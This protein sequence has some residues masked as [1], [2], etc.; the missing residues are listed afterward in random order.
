M[1]ERADSM[2]KMVSVLTFD[3]KLKVNH[4]HKRCAHSNV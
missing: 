4:T 3:T 2:G 1:S